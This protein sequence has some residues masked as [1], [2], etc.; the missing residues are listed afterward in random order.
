MKVFLKNQKIEYI[1]GSPYHPQSQG[2][3][4]GFNRTIQNF[5]YLS[6]DMNL[7]EFNLNNSVYD[8]CMYYNNRIH[9]TTRF[10]SQEVIKKWDDEFT[11]SIYNNIV[12]A[13][14]KS[15]IDKFIE[16]QIVRISNYLKISRDGKYVMY[17]KAKILAKNIKKE[18]FQMKGKKEFMQINSYHKWNE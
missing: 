5:L 4:E 10:K 8:F 2:A 18:I 14:R 12:D 11:L 9:S 13:R 17:Y 15:K 7:D 1:R 6:K 16:G 3:V